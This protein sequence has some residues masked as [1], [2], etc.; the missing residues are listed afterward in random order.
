MGSLFAII[1]KC[2]TIT[3]IMMSLIRGKSDCRF[4]G[5]TAEPRLNCTDNIAGVVVVVD[6]V[7][8]I[9]AIGVRV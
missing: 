2:N 6:V 8:V 4:I 7:V 9:V 5:R 3:T 1:A